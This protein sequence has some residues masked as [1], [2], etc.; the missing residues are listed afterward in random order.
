MGECFFAD[1]CNDDTRGRNVA[2]RAK[3][4]LRVCASLVIAGCAGPQPGPPAPP[5]RQSVEL[6]SAREAL[7]SALHQCTETY[8]Y[9]PRTAT[10]IPEH[11]LAAHELQW[12]QCAYSAVRTYERANPKLAPMYEQLISL[13]EQMTNEITAG[14]LTRSER[15]TRTEEELKAIAQ[16]E[17]AQIAAANLQQAQQNQQIQNVIDTIRMFGITGVRM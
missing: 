17:H 1:W 11:A 12:N 13:Y 16:A 15:H 8:S 6:L 9:S 5:S 4:L 2:M 14:T 7:N 10:D 3:P